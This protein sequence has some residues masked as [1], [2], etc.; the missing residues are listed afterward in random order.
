MDELRS[1]GARAARSWVW[2]AGVAALC[3]GVPVGLALSGAFRI[4][5]TAAAAGALMTTGG[6]GLARTAWPGWRQSDL[7]RLLVSVGFFVSCA[8]AILMLG[9]I[10][11]YH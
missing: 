8:G 7:R 6:L 3:A 9:G 2:L 4:Q 11:L 5:V 10:G 1:G